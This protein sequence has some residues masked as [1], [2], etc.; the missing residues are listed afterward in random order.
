MNTVKLMGGLGNQLFQYAFGEAMMLNGIDVTFDNSWYKRLKL[1]RYPRPY[2]LDKLN[3]CDCTQVGHFGHKRK[4]IEDG[5]NADYLHYD[6]YDFYGYWQYLRYF[7]HILPILKKEFVVRSEFHTNQ[8]KEHL[9]KLYLDKVDTVSVHVRRGD[10]LLQKGWG[11]LPLGYYMRAIA[12]TKGNLYFFSDDITWCKNTFKQSY[13]PERKLIFIDPME[14]H[15]DFEL[16]KHFKTNI[17]SNSTFSYWAAMCNY[18]KEHKV[19]SPGRWL[20][21]TQIDYDGT[22][23]PKEWEKIVEY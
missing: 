4:I 16:M 3:I 8:Y 6:Y 7:Q 11:A 23:Y 17:I 9:E 2:C 15:L 21:E 13:F 12:M 19:I 20:G 10:Y 22:H 5:F 1:N 14:P 18:G